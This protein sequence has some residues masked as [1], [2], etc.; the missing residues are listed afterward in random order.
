MSDGD[1]AGFLWLLAIGA[2]I[3]A[4]NNHE[5]LQKERAE[6][7]NEIVKVDQK[8]GDLETRIIGLERKMEFA[9]GDIARSTKVQ[10]RIVET[11]NKNVD[12]DNRQSV[13]E[14]TARGACGTERVDFEDGGWTIRNKECTL[15]DLR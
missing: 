12:M 7:I 2:T 10:D 8:I 1:G 3:W 5:K 14:M 6:R 13:R 4:W 9:E 11:F 15:K